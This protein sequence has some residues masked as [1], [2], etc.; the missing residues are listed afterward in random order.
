[1]TCEEAELLICEYVDRVLPEPERAALEAHMA[2][3]ASCAALAKDAAYA[4][5]FIDRVPKVEPP[6]ALITSILQKTPAAERSATQP[7]RFWPQLLGKWF[8]PLGQPRLVMGMAMTVLS[9]AMLGR[10]AGIEA[11]QIQPAD[12]HPVKVWQATE[13]SLH[14][15]WLR[16]V[17]YYE[18]LKF[19]YEIRSRL[20]ELTEADWDQDEPSPDP[21]RPE[22]ARG[23]RTRGGDGPDGAK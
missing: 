13:D 6:P 23:E 17:K 12:L 2:G 8:E 14:R 5:A 22:G 16:A 9:F 3:C 21:N 18:S 7:W 11:R 10:F 20:N 1:M 19:V 4:V 15:L